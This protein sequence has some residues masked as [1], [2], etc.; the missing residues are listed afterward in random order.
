MA[1]TTGDVSGT[2]AVADGAVYFGDFGGTLWKLDADTGA[3]L[4]QHAVPDYRF[5][6]LNK[7]VPPLPADGTAMLV[8]VKPEKVPARLGSPRALLQGFFRAMDS[9]DTNDAAV[10]DAIDCLDL[11]G[12]PDK[13]RRSLGATLA[14]KLESVLRAQHVDLSAVPDKILLAGK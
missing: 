10:A 13:D 11:G 5:A 1:T 6:R 7:V 9:A 8:G 14:G 4:W 2:P 12:I 3:V